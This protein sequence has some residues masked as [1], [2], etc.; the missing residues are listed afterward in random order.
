MIEAYVYTSGTHEVFNDVCV[1]KPLSERYRDVLVMGC[2]HHNVAQS[3]IDYLESLAIIPRK[4]PSE[5]MTIEKLLNVS[6]EGLEEWNNDK[7][8]I[9]NGRNGNP[10]YMS[11]NGKVL[12]YN[13]DEN[14]DFYEMILTQM[15]GKSIELSYCKLLYDPKYGVFESIEEFTND[16]CAEIEDGYCSTTLAKQCE[17]IALYHQPYRLVD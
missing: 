9:G 13:C 6:L 16:H 17:I 8:T 11:I 15:A 2:K 1:N 5:R 4:I 3:H 14:S 7:I 10:V 12:K